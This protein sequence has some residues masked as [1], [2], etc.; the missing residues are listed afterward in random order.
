MDDDYIG[1]HDNPLD[2]GRYTFAAGGAAAASNFDRL[3][4]D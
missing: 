1:V 4:V 3:V 2:S